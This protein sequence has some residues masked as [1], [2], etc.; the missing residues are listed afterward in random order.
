MDKV[1]VDA[2][3]LFITYQIVASA[4]QALLGILYNLPK[5]DETVLPAHAGKQGKLLGKSASTSAEKLP[6]QTGFL[7]GFFV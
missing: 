1:L 7:K 5:D 2:N 3:A 6:K 4:W